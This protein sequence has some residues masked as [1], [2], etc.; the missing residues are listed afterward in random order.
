MLQIRLRHML[1]FSIFQWILSIPVSGFFPRPL[2]QYVFPPDIYPADI[3][4][5][6]L[7][8]LIVAFSS[9]AALSNR[10]CLALKCHSFL[11]NNTSFDW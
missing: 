6:R 5:N 8:W 7:Q 4:K 10:F 1:C 2:P 11:L 9:S 3:I